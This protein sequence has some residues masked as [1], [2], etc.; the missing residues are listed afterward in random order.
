MW[1]KLT[2]KRQVSVS[3]LFCFMLFCFVGRVKNLFFNVLN[4]KVSLH[5][6]GII[7]YTGSSLNVEFRRDFWHRVINLSK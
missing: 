6:N 5:P 4:F 7:E 1:S 2:G 3:L